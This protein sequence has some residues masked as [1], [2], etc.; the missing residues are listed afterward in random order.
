LVKLMANP[1]SFVLLKGR[2]VPTNHCLNVVRCQAIQDGFNQK[3]RIHPL[4]T[5]KRKSDTTPY[6]FPENTHNN[7]ELFY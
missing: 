3:E 1:A 2:N 5:L 6:L 4:S 7:L